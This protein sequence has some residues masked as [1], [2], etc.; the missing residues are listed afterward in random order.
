ML[1]LLW[2]GLTQSV[3]SLNRTKRLTLSPARQTF[4][5]LLAFELGHWLFPTSDLVQW[6]WD[7]HTQVPPSS[8][9]PGSHFSLPT[10]WFFLGSRLQTSP[11][12]LVTCPPP[13]RMSQFFTMNLFSLRH[14]RPVVLFLRRTLTNIGVEPGFKPRQLVPASST[15]L[16]CESAE[17]RGKEGGSLGVHCSVQP[18]HPKPERLA[19]L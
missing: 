5:C 2:V 12:D 6:G 13:N 7:Q 1:S 15:A 10:F 11:P 14:T 4:S 16:H 9:L 17:R 8:R 18:P 3:E 19:R